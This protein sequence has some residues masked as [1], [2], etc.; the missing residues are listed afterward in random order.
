MSTVF[1]SSAYHFLSHSVRTE[2]QYLLIRFS[3]FPCVFLIP[4]PPMASISFLPFYL[5]LSHTAQI[6]NE[7]TAL[8]KQP[9]IDNTANDNNDTLFSL[10]SPRRRDDA[11]LNRS[12]RRNV[13]FSEKYMLAILIGASLLFLGVLFLVFTL[14]TRLQG[15]KRPAVVSTHSSDTDAE[16]ACSCATHLRLLA[17]GVISLCEL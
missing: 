1:E 14:M 17:I 13:I 16:N 4:P 12:V 9:H 5:S 15:W 10:S 8:L 11:T 2:S 6:P 7:S 3:I